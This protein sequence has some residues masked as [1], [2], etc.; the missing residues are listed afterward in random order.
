MGRRVQDIFVLIL[1]SIES[2]KSQRLELSHSVLLPS[3]S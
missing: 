2:G 1:G 3:L